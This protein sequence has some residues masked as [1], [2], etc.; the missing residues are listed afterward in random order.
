MKIKEHVRKVIGRSIFDSRGI[1]TVEVDIEASFATARA[2]CPSGASTGSQEALELRDGNNSKC[3][4]KS[5]QKALI[6]VEELA[7]SLISTPLE[8]T[9]QAAIDKHMV[10]LD[11]T[12]NKSRV[13]AN[14]ILPISICFSRLGARCMKVQDWEYIQMLVNNDKMYP[15]GMCSSAP[16]PAAPSDKSQDLPDGS[17]VVENSNAEKSVEKSAEKEVEQSAAN[18][19]VPCKNVKSPEGCRNSVQKK[20]AGLTI[21]K[22]FFNIINGGRHSD[23]GLFVQEIMVS[24]E[25]NAPY[26]VLSCASEFIWA[27][28]AI[29]KKRYKLTGVGDEGGFAPPI[30]SL[31]EGLDLIQEASAASGIK[32]VIALDV[33]ASEFY[34]NGKYNI[35]WKTKDKFLT[36]A[37]MI[38]Y[39]IK[40]IKKY[41]VVMIED[42]FDEKDYEGWAKFMEEAAKLNVQIVGDDLIVTNP[43]LIKKAGEKKLCNV[44]LIKMNQIGTITET[45]QAVKE[46]RHQGMKIMASHRSGETEDIF[47]SHLSVGL[48]ADYLKAGSLCRSERVSKYNELVRIFEKSKIDTFR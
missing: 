28:K 3:M 13:G 41:K 31:E 44:A 45:I 11:G 43:E 8:I 14:S 9:D 37:E 6:G 25:G 30:N 23:N 19:S 2:S 12:K 36:Q 16:A 32:P 39:Y 7:T 48:S 5:V 29:V 38:E 18:E 24:F 20:N 10:S 15:C 17:V 46:A 33:A 27:L 47:L 22:I 1:P 40:I 35:G 26:T 34:Q 42:P 21:P 4:G